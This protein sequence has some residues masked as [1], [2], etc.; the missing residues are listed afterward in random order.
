MV[1]LLGRLFI[2][3]NGWFTVFKGL[4]G[5]AALASPLLYR[6]L[7]RECLNHSASDLVWS[8]ELLRLPNRYFW[9]KL[10]SMSLLSTTEVAARLN[11]TPQRVRALIAAGR[12]PAR[13]VGR[14]HLIEESDLALV[15]D[16]KPGRPPS[17]GSDASAHATQTGSAKKTRA[18][19]KSR[20][21][22]LPT[23]TQKN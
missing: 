14:D 2:T 15:A 23:K 20:K 22:A 16:R 1:K 6:D 13:K 11:V 8:R 5:V 19:K 7:V 17:S 9:I 4:A 18:T 3:P 10:K 21:T 12:L